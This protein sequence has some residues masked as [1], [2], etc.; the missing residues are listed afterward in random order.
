MKRK[1]IL[2]PGVG[3]GKTLT[4]ILKL[5]DLSKNLRNLVFLSCWVP[6]GSRL[7]ERLRSHRLH[8]RVAGSLASVGAGI[9]CGADMVRVHDVEETVKFIQVFRAILEGM[10]H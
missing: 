1:I 3:F 8:G 10:N 2:D 5:F 4:T 9:I 7:L 6:P